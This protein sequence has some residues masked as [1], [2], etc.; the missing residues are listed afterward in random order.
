LRFSFV[1]FFALVAM[2]RSDDVFSLFDSDCE[3]EE[4]LFGDSDGEF[5][6]EDFQGLLLALQRRSQRSPCAK[7]SALA[8]G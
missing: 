7:R 5:D 6:D 2:D 8:S 1:G 3:L 4:E